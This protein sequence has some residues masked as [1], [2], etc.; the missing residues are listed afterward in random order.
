MIDKPYKSTLENCPRCGKKEI[1]DI[2]RDHQDTVIEAY[3]VC[4]DNH[5]IR[6][7]NTSAVVRAAMG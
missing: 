3:A 7:L 6:V 5:A 4:P 1:L 2:Y